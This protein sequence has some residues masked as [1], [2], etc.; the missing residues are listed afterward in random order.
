ML[1]FFLVTHRTTVYDLKTDIVP[2]KKS[3]K[4]EK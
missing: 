2:K 1:E 4:R 3:D